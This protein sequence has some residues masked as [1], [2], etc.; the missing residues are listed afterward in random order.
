[1]N[2]AADT[3][4]ITV[5]SR[6]ELLR[7]RVQLRDVTLAPN[8]PANLLVQTRAHGEPFAAR[9]HGDTLLFET[10]QRRVAPGQVV[11]CY[12]GDVLLGGGIAAA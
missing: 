5:G 12:D 7:D 4:T 1:V 8:S 9:L 6:D 2:I 10:P 3:A 11:A